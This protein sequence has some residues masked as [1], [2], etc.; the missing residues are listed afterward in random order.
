MLIDNKRQPQ[1][2]SYSTPLSLPTSSTT[3]S[4]DTEDLALMRQVVNQDSQAFETLYARYAPSLR[5]YLRRSLPP[6]AH[7]EEVLNDVMMALW[8]GAARVPPSVPLAAWLFGIARRQ[9]LKAWSLEARCDLPA[10]EGTEESTTT[11]PESDLLYQERLTMMK[12]FLNRLPSD[13]RRL[14]ELTVD[15]GLSYEEISCQTHMNVNTIKSRLSR[16]RRRLRA[17]M[18]AQG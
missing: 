11:T 17:Y 14:I 3:I 13:Q 16:A 4:D 9:N 6:H 15:Q 10:Q 5:A 8:R 2:P 12:R 1:S 18:L 7:V